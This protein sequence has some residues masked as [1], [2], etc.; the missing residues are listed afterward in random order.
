MVLRFVFL[1]QG[2]KYLEKRGIIHRDLAARNVLGKINIKLAITF[3]GFLTDSFA[4]IAMP[5]SAYLTFVTFK[6]FNRLQHVVSLYTC[7]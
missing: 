4:Y 1:F 3:S 5:S 6:I 2:M 7:I